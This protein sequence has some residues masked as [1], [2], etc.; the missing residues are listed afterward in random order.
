MAMVLIVFLFLGGAALGFL[1][2]YV[3]LI[4]AVLSYCVLGLVSY[5]VLANGPGFWGLVLGCVVLQIGYL[6]GALMASKPAK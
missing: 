4:I 2:R 5:L 6:V 1:L 3:F